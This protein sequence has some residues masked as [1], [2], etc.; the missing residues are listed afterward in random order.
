MENGCDEPQAN[1][2]S[3]KRTQA[4]F[5]LEMLEIVSGEDND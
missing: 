5:N 3:S 2:D 4:L 1:N